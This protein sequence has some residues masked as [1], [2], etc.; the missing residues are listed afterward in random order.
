MQNIH[1][2]FVHFPIALILS[3]FAL[4]ALG[5]V[6]KRPNFHIAGRLNVTLGFLGACLSVLTGLRAEQTV[7]QHSYEI[8]QLM[9]AHGRIGL[10]ILGLSFALT[11]WRW[12]AR[13]IFIQKIRFLY[14]ISY[15]I[16]VILVFYA[17]YLGGRM[18]YE[19]N[20]GGTVSTVV[21]NPPH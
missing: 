2:I 6:L 10:L 5:S 16:L 9:E 15:A 14:F 17:G 8:H 12:L 21:I 19:Y 11:L 18:V 13:S 1:P 4:D 3:G 7:T 20:V